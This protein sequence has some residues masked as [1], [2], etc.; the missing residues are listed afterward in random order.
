MIILGKFEG[1]PDLAEPEKNSVTFRATYI[2]TYVYFIFPP[3]SDASISWMIEGLAD[4]DFRNI[5]TFSVVCE[6]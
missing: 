3:L 1:E 4:Q 5:S 6:S 2:F